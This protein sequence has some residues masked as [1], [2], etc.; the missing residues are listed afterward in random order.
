M[1]IVKTDFILDELCLSLPALDKVSQLVGPYDQS[2]HE[3]F[4]L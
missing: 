1:D 2:Y 3:I 4:N